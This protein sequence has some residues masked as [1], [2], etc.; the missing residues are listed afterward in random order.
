MPI[1]RR[2]GWFETVP[3]PLFLLWSLALGVGCQRLPIRLAEPQ[4]AAADLKRQDDPL[5][6]LPATR[7]GAIAT[8][9][10]AGI[11]SAPAGTP[12][13]DAAASL[14]ERLSEPDQAD[15]SGAEPFVEPV[16]LPDPP[17]LTSAEDAATHAP[18]APSSARVPAP[19]ELTESPNALV[20][21]KPIN[22]D[23][24]SAPAR[25]DDEH[26][27]GDA[28]ERLRAI[29]RQGAGAPG[30][31]AETWMIRAQ[32]LDWMAGS[33]VG[34][35]T[36]RVWTTVLT[37]L[38]ASAS[39]ETP[40]P[41]ASWVKLRAGIEAL[42]SLTPLSVGHLALCQ[43]IHGF[44]NFE[45]VQVEALRAG[46]PILIYCELNGLRSV[47]SADGFRSRIS[48]QVEIVHKEGGD[49][50]WS[51]ALGM[52]EDLCR[53]PR[54]DYYVNYRMTLPANLAPGAYELRLTQTD[55]VAD[56]SETAVLTLHIRP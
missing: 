27:W 29:S 2:L 33:G 10:T 35:E 37:A 49:P 30:E 11:S 31:A 6:P 32:L 5:P 17:S 15:P 41:E 51:Q 19:S 14:A 46:Q 22:P 20:A 53:R 13:L 44:G 47:P 7:A 42:E 25:R 45:P 52:A 23:K 12:L 50:V 16:V 21:P 28:L 38:S 39:E 54:R 56:R 40:D 55:L 34:S 18:A 3:W 48:S 24:P 26:E 4:P 43:R 8:A 1:G 36:S 9:P